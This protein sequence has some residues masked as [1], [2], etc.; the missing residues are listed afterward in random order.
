M[1]TKEVKSNNN[2]SQAGLMQLADDF[3]NLAE[4]DLVLLAIL[5]VTAE[6]LA[7]LRT[8]NEEYKN[9][10]ADTELLAS[11]SMFSATK[12]THAENVRETLR[13]ISA[14][15]RKVFS[16]NSAEYRS[17]DIQSFSRLNDETLYRIGK[18]IVRVARQHLQQ[19]AVKGQTAEELDTLEADLLQF[20]KDID[21]VKEAYRLR[22]QATQ[23]RTLLGNEIYTIIS[24]ISDSGK[25]YWVSR[26]KV[27]YNEYI[28]YDTPTGHKTG[29]TVA[30]GV[31]TGLITDFASGNP[32]KDVVVSVVVN[33]TA[34]TVTTDEN[35]EYALAE[36][37]VGIYSVT[38]TLADYTTATNE[39]VE[40]AEDE[41]TTCDFEMKKP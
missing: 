31:I 17:F 6:M 7:A 24:E 29:T 36:I 13:M 22:E 23:S 26:D 12:D 3:S 28:I 4:R 34:T 32:L 27:K 14:R 33:G 16:E 21:N 35:G 11:V 30:S 40:V 39:N 2:L 37:P 19:L 5:G 25:E 10:P 18:Q 20:D 8:K 38:A 15:V 9:M 41:D 1:E